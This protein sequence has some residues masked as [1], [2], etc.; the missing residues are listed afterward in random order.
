MKITYGLVPWCREY[1]EYVLEVTLG[2]TPLYVL[3]MHEVE[4]ML[5]RIEPCKGKTR[6]DWEP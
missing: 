2:K 6:Q 1:L 5:K 3:L 4:T